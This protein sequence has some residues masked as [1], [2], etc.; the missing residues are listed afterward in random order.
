MQIKNIYK[1]LCIYKDIRKTQAI[2]NLNYLSFFIYVLIYDFKFIATY[3][4]FEISK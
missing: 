3:N 4:I 2:I 1:Y